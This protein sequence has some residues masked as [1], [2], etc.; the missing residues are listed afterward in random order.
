VKTEL[1]KQNY[2]QPGMVNTIIYNWSDVSADLWNVHTA[3]LLKDMWV[4]VV[5]NLMWEHFA[6]Q[7][8]TVDATL[9]A[10]LHEE[11][12]ISMRVFKDFTQA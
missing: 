1:S 12:T 10:L 7:T 9:L 5:W 2:K 6:L 11:L 4:E 3:I 8:F